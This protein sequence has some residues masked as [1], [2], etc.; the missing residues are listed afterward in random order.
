MRVIRRLSLLA[1]LP[2]LAAPLAE[3]QSKAGEARAWEHETSDI[4]VNPRLKFGALANGLRYSWM[5]NTEPQKRCYVRLHVNVGSLAED[6]DERGIAHFL[7]HMAFNGTRHYPPG[8]LIEWFQKHGMGFGADTNAHTGLG[9]T[10]YQLDLPQ[11]DEK[12][13]DEGLTVLRDFADG[14]LLEEKE[15]EAEKGVIDGE[16]RER[17]SAGYRVL[18]KSLAKQFAG[19]R[20]AVRLPIGAKAVRD[21][22]DAAKIRAFYRKWYRPEN[23][24][25]AVVGDLG[26][27]D[28]APFVERVFGDMKPPST[29]PAP[30][31]PMGTPSGAEKTFSIYESEIPNVTVAVERLVPWRDDRVTVANWARDE[32]LSFARRMLNLRFVELAKKADAP[33]LQARVGEGGGGVRV[34][35][36]E[37]LSVTAVPG[38]W[39]EAFAFA[40]QELRRALEH[41]F[42]EA[43]LNEVRADMLRSLDE[44]VEREKT[45]SSLSFMGEIL[46]AAEERSVPTDAETDRRILRPIVLGL[47]AKSCHDAFVKAWG[48]GALFLSTT[49]NLDLGPDAPARLAEAYEASRK[50]AVT[51]GAE[52]ASV[53]FAYASNAARAGRVKSRRHVEDLD[54][55]ELVFE[56]GVKVNIKK[57]DFKEKQI[58]VSA[59]LGEGA[60]TLAPSESELAQVASRVFTGMGLVAHS[61]DDVRRL[62]AGREVGVAFSAEQDEFVLGGATT[63]EDLVLQCELIAA[64]MQAPGWRADG[65]TQ[66]MR[67]VPQFYEALQHQPDGPLVQKFIPALYSGDP[68][69]GLPSREKVEAVTIDRLRQWLTPQLAKGPL[70][71][72]IVGDLDIEAAVAAAART[73]GTLPRRRAEDPLDARRKV[74]A[75]RTGLQMVEP[76]ASVVPKSLVVATF[77]STDGIEAL[78]RRRLSLLASVLN[79]RLRVQVRETLGAS[80]SPSARSEASTVYPGNG[81]LLVRAMAEPAKVQALVEA[82]VKAAD[83]LATGGVAQEELDRLREPI[84]ATLRDILRTNTHW[85]SVLAESQ[86]RPVVLD[87][88]RHLVDDYKGM[89]PETISSLAAEYL[90]KDRAS[91]LVVNPLAPA[92]PSAAPSAP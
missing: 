25:V 78:R 28:P 90:K 18:E 47:T 42:Q 92:G 21:R 69:F 43:E 30:E 12:S 66:Y 34:Y 16:E 29:P 3:A 81:L 13:L 67:S 23:M 74:P 15:I 72:A 6:D 54:I 38:K 37:S 19:T 59:R 33:F 27:L 65:M 32:A 9:E 53:P 1:V 80:Y 51:A 45:R 58:L 77:P 71:V 20:V 52:A 83:D 86:R 61:A 39:K 62:T 4:P 75:V 46:A 7:E 48:E 91:V 17:D 88:A 82:C 79:D 56:N 87:E 55:H 36:G 50:V 24:T 85:T 89:T 84:L 31:P 10:V 41:G 5:S 68:R 57:T 63:R 73:F 44:G 14:A 11:S 60:L 2:L 8:T 22:F 40:E 70:E 26:A 76:V 35:D 49:G 64:Y